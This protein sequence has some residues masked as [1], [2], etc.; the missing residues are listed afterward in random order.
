MI[1]PEKYFHKFD[2]GMCP[3]PSV[4]YTPMINLGSVMQSKAKLKKYG[5]PVDKV[6]GS[7]PSVSPAPQITGGIAYCS[8]L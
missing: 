7:M 6:H 1:S 4:S 5:E 8:R 2:G 3:P